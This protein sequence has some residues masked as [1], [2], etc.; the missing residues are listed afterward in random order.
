MIV[1]H[2][3]SDKLSIVHVD[4]SEPTRDKTSVLVFAST[5]DDTITFDLVLCSSHRKEPEVE[6]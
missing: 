3:L 1:I 5:V 4:E 2:F 6:I